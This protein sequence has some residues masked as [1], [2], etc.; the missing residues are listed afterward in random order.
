V[1]EYY[2]EGLIRVL[3]DRFDPDE[4]VDLMQLTSRELIEAFIVKAYD[5]AAHE[6]IEIPESLDMDDE[7]APEEL[8]DELE[9]LQLV[10]EEDYL[11]EITKD[12][13]EY[14]ENGD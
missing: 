5:L 6:G 4:L 11:N 14:D 10:E 7:D 9:G 13:E 8:E 12:E 1:G 2:N 3:S